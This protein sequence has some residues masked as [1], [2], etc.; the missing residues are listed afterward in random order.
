MIFASLL[1]PRTRPLVA[2]N[3]GLL[4]SFG[5]YFFTFGWLLSRVAPLMARNASR[6]EWAGVHLLVGMMVG[7]YPDFAR[8][9][10][11]HPLPEPVELSQPEL[12][13][14]N[15]TAS[16]DPASETNPLEAPSASAGHLE[17]AANGGPA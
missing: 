9:L 12:E 17:D 6:L 15:M 7:L 1:S 14:V 13:A 3:A 11:R 5:C 4:F 16:A 2:T 8:G 10:L